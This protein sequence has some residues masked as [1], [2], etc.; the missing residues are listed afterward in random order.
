MST[1]LDGSHLVPA[2]QPPPRSLE[3]DRPDGL[4]EALRHLPPGGVLLTES[5]KR[6][7]FP[8]GRGAVPRLKSWGMPMREGTR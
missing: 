7:T 4:F 1:S 6:M 8:F 2:R 5:F 3:H